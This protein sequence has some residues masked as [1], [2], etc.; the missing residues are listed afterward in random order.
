MTTLAGSLVIRTSSD[1]PLIIISNS[2][3][4][5]KMLSMASGIVNSKLVFPAGIV[6]LYGPGSKS[7]PPKH[8]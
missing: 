7:L 5:S 2:S 8:V 1:V 4:N 3:S 6:R